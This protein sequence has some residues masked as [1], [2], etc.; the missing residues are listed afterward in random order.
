[1]SNWTPPPEPVTWTLPKPI[2]H[3]GVRYT[4]VTL[5]APLVED[6]LKASALQG[7]SP[8]DMTRRLIAAVSVEQL[9]DD[10]ALKIPDW[11]AGQM[12]GY[13]DSF[14]GAPE[15]VP[16]EEW[17]AAMRAAAAALASSASPAPAS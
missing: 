17:R 13:L 16:L 1:M 6:V 3:N 2:D 12:S 15:P 8:Y 4:T 11:M 9:P 5:R 10:V 7:A 14:A